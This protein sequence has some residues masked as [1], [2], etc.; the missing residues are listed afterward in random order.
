M[1]ANN[2]FFLFSEGTFAFCKL[3]KYELSNLGEVLIGTFVFVRFCDFTA[4]ILL[5]VIFGGHKFFC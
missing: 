3:E 4:G 1:Y 2:R 5:A